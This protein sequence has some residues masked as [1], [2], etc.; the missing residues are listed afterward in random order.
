MPLRNEA[1]R[2]HLVRCFADALQKSIGANREGQWSCAASATSGP[3]LAIADSGAL[4]MQVRLRGTL[5]GELHIE[6]READAKSVFQPG[7]SDSLHDAWQGILEGSRSAA[8]KGKKWACS[9][10]V[11]N[12]MHWRSQPGPLFKLERSS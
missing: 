5:S 6:S 10:S 11:S 3:T 8:A 1:A 7:E 9:P 4:V 2:V 12:H